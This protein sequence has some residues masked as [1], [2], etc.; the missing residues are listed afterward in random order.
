MSDTNNNALTALL[1][2]LSE[3]QRALYDQATAA[4][5]ASAPA[6]TTVSA[7]AGNAV[8]TATG[9]RVSVEA[10]AAIAN[11][12]HGGTPNGPPVTMRSA[13][14]TPAGPTEDTPI[15]SMSRSD[16]KGLLDRLIAQHGFVEGNRQ[17]ANRHDRELASR[18]VRVRPRS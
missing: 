8:A 2:S 12:L 16:Q 5:P 11:V 6:P 4:K 10:L 1:G 15:L 14:P 9:E 18:N 7:P 3:E 17:F 13:P